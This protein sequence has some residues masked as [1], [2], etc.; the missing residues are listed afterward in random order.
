MLFGLGACTDAGEPTLTTIR[1]GNCGEI[2]VTGNPSR[3]VD[4]AAAQ[5]ASACFARAFQACVATTLTIRDE[6][7]HTIRQ[8]A[9]SP[10]SPCNLRQALQTDPTLPP[11]MADCKDA[12]IEN[13][14]LVIETCSDLGTFILNY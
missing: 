7:N 14:T 12:H 6:T 4:P 5:S 8:F 9:I 1:D 2:S 13:N 11:A 3:A 10:V